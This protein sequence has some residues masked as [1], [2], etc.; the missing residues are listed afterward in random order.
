MRST[1]K[2]T[3]LD[4]NPCDVLRIKGNKSWQTLEVFSDGD[5][6]PADITEAGRRFYSDG[7]MKLLETGQS[8]PANICYYESIYVRAGFGTVP[9]IRMSQKWLSG[10]LYVIWLIIPIIISWITMLGSRGGRQSNG[11]HHKDLK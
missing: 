10:S 1:E 2:D 7:S 5:V 3:W 6:I 9:Y 8:P 4:Y 11:L